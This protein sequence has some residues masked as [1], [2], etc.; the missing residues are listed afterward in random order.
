[1]GRH[2][3]HGMRRPYW[4]FDSLDVLAKPS[5]I[6]HLALW[7]TPPFQRLHPLRRAEDYTQREKQGCVGPSE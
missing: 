6:Q 5:F 7:W 3:R 1:M 4:N 2:A